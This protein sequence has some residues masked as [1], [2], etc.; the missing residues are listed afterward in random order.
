MGTGVVSHPNPGTRPSWLV[1]SDASCLLISMKYV[2]ATPSNERTSK[3]GVARPK[4]QT[5]G[6]PYGHAM[7]PQREHVSQVS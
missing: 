5:N 6:R 2:T 3:H 4:P 7:H 1:G